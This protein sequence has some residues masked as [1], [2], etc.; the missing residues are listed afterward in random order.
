MPSESEGIWAK[1]ADIWY[2]LVGVAAVFFAVGGYLGDLRAAEDALELAQ[3]NDKEID[4]VSRSVQSLNR[5]VRI[6]ICSRPDLGQQVR[7]R[8]NCAQFETRP[9]SGE[10]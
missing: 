5:T 2:V 9:R 4:R 8:L 6:Y 10:R 3:E 7:F 1:L